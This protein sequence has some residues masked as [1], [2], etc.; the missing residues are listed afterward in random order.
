M[1]GFLSM[2]ST[3]SWCVLQTIRFERLGKG[4]DQCVCVLN[5]VLSSFFCFVLF[6][7]DISWS[8]I[9]TE[10]PLDQLLHTVLNK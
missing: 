5:R 8:V 3:L 4:G 7:K 9:Y 2:L 6:F 10:V 1:S